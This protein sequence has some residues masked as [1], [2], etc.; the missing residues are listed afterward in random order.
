[1]YLKRAYIENSGSL[2]ELDLKFSFDSTG[3]PKP[4]IMVGGNGGGKT[5]FLSLVADA[6]FEAAAVHYENVLP[7]SG[8]GRSWFRVVGGKTVSLGASGSVS[9][10]HFDDEGVDRFFK[11]KAGTIDAEALKHRAPA[12]FEGQCN[13]PLNQDSVKVFDIPDAQSK[14]AFE[15]G[16]YSYFPS[17]RSEI[18]YWLNVEALPTAEFDLRPKFSKRLHKPIYVEHALHDFTQWL[19]GVI[20]DVRTEIWP[21]TQGPQTQWAFRGD[22]FA[23]MQVSPLLESDSKLSGVSS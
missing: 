17:N 12:I 3:Q 20:A 22:P 19:L 23:A 18:P 21:E 9:L 2:R 8:Q 14:L 13:W 7:A 4:L 6:L 10:L 16:A 1:M 15:R 5:N 11:E